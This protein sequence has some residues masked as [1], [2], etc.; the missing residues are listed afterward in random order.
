[1]K[2]INVEERISLYSWLGHYQYGNHKVV[3]DGVKGINVEE[4]IS[5]YSW[6]GHYQYGNHKEV[7]I[8]VQYIS[9]LVK[10][11]KNMEFHMWHALE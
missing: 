8:I 5:L 7:H 4:R 2:G 1:M 9:N 6:L 3:H 11:K 10:I